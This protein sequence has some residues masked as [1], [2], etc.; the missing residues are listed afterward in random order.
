MSVPFRM[1]DA[2]AWTGGTLLQGRY[3]ILGVIGIGGMGA[4]YKA[5]DLRF[6]GVMRV[7]AVKEMMNTAGTWPRCSP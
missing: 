7:C 4:V 5:Q 6:S 2:A 1:R 3:R